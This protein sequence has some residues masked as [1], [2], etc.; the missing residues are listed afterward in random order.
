MT[1]ADRNGPADAQAAAGRARILIV[2]AAL[3]ALFLGALD[4][5]V[6]GAAMPTIV[7]DLGG[8]DL[9][10]WVFSV[11]LLTRAVA[12]PIFGKL[13]DLYS[14][15]KLFLL[16]IGI[17]LISSALAGMARSMG[18]LIVFRALQGIGA[19]GNFAL[20]YYVVSELSEPGRR[21]KMMGLISFVWGVS[22][23][24]GPPLGG[25]IVSYADWRW[26]FFLNL[27]IGA[28]ALAAIW[29]YLGETRERPGRPVIDYIGAL[30]LSSAVVCLL[31]ACL[32]AGAGRGWASLQVLGLLAGAVFSAI[33]F[34]YAETRSAEPIL[35][36]AF[37]RIPGFSLGNGSAFLC[38]FAI[39]SLSA[40]YPLFIQGVMGKSPAQLGL[41]MIPLSLGWSV[42]AW[43]YGQL[44]Q[45][46]AHK[47]ASLI[48]SFMLMAGCA[49]SLL[50]GSTTSIVLCSLVLALCGLG[51]GFVSI[52]TLLMVQDSISAQGLGVATASHQFARTLGGTIGIGIAGGLVSFFIKSTLGAVA[53]P[54][55]STRLGQLE[56]SQLLNNL[57]SLFSPRVQGNLTE[58]AR[59]LLTQAVTNGLQAVFWIALLA[60][61]LSFCLG[62]LMPNTA[63][64]VLMPRPGTA[65]LPDRPSNSGRI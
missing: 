28:L 22:S 62:I 42:G 35:P 16:A 21:G 6:V 29:F 9:Y 31:G 33:A 49:S 20:T 53:G 19:G 3:A 1:N 46:L 25:F 30:T 59:E 40:F 11:Y 47:P 52:G 8:L 64:G 26:I 38:S 61:A 10:S 58:P 12:L 63:P 60:S 17:F 13:C 50:L 5:L 51:M 14:S 4:A 45:R 65:G 15:R 36:L 27:P 55:E 32:L 39:F 37:F 57:P 7:S 56:P 2:A 44:S 18:Q 54:G 41:S 34:G 43:V 24:L 48:G 23:L